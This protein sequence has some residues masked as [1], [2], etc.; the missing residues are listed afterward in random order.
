MR[1]RQQGMT[2]IGFV[3]IAAMV[4]I[5]GYGGIRLI[6]IYL[7]QMKVRQTLSELKTEYDGQEATPKLLSS[8]IEKHLDVEMVDFPSVRDFRIS[9]TDTGYRV[10]VSYEDRAPYIANIAFV[11]T[12]DNAV[13]IRR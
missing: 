6:P 1:N 4:G 11:A 13:E 5:I 8:A 12:F 3:L 2:A 7:T 9:K 10:E